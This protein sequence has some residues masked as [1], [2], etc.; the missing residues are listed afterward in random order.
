M[1]RGKGREV[2]GVRRWALQVQGRSNHNK[3]ACA[4]ANKLARICYA[5][6]RDKE[7][8]DEAQSLPK[9][10]NRQAFAMPA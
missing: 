4:L 7:K 9:K 1:A 8:F 3:A 2:H 5:T 6:L 10:L